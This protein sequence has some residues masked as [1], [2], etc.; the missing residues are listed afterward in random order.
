MAGFNAQGSNIEVSGLSES[1]RLALIAFEK[2][3]NRR[4]PEI[5]PELKGQGMSVKEDGDPSNKALEYLL[6]KYVL[7]DDVISQNPE[8]QELK[9]IYKSLPSNVRPVPLP[10]NNEVNE[11]SSFTD[12]ELAL[13]SFKQKLNEYL[14]RILPETSDMAL[15]VDG[16]PLDGALIYILDNYIFNGD[17]ITQN[18]ELLE[19][20]NSYMNL[21]DN[22]R[23]RIETYKDFFIRPDDSKGFENQ[24][25]AVLE[26]AQK[27]LGISE[28]SPSSKDGIKVEIGTR[29]ARALRARIEQLQDIGEISNDL[30]PR[31]FDQRVVEALDHLVKDRMKDASIS[32]YSELNSMI[33]NLWALGKSKDGDS[34]PTRE[35]LDLGEAVSLRNIM[36]FIVNSELPSG[37]K[38]PTPVIDVRWD[39]QWTNNDSGDRFFNDATYRDLYSSKFTATDVLYDKSGYS[40]ENYRVLIKASE[41]LGI[42]MRNGRIMSELEVGRIATEILS[43]K[44]QDAWCMISPDTEFDEKKI[45]E[46]IH[47]GKF[48]PHIDDL[49]L[50]EKG[51]GLPQTE[52][53]RKKVDEYGPKESWRLEFEERT[54]VLAYRAQEFSNRFGEIPQYAVTQK[55]IAEH[56]TENHIRHSYGTPSLYFGS[57]R[58][59]FGST[60]QTKYEHDRDIYLEKYQ[61]FKEDIGT[62][63]VEPEPVKNP[64][65]LDC[66]VES[67][68]RGEA[69]RPAADC[70]VEAVLLRGEDFSDKTKLDRSIDECI[71]SNISDIT[72]G[73]QGECSVEG[74]WDN[75]LDY[76]N[77]IKP[78]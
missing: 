6:R 5:L 40:E 28:I 24:G 22:I 51:F 30:D 71:S 76:K 20:R 9:D 59:L 62:C 52:F 8:M 65:N 36:N 32:S 2:T 26:Q 55:A 41:R 19:L 15:K 38:A 31:E 42:D 37:A 17:N 77:I 35:E 23:D 57:V 44:A 3:L 54:G 25:R 45:H 10:E 50:A 72:G 46:M 29:T 12:E 73:A 67:V 16:N 58:S 61:K 53:F 43:L 78:N 14:P 49:A 48:M 56:E 64:E 34:L 63:D 1:E 39:S 27:Y 75:R 7:N 70:S 18:P 47:A 74:E 68:I 21:P 60:K 4:L 13:A 11:V 66:T 69:V 33:V